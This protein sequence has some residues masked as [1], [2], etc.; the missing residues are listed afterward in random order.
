M[1]RANRGGDRECIDRRIL[2]DV[3]QVRRAW[4]ARITARDV[5]EDI[6]A[7][8]TEVADLGAFEIGEAADEVWPPVAEPHDRHSDDPVAFPVSVAKVR[9]Q[10]VTPFRRSMSGVRRSRRRSRPRDHPR[11]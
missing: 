6:R 3:I 2:E 9:H 11:A 8:V 10:R 7:E 1:V 5:L 4:D